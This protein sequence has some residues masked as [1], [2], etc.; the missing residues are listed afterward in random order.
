MSPAQPGGLWQASRQAVSKA[1]VPA[2]AAPAWFKQIGCRLRDLVSVLPEAPARVLRTPGEIDLLR[3]AIAALNEKNAALE[4]QITD[5]SARLKAHV[6][7]GRTGLPMNLTAR[8]QVLKMARNGR[9]PEQ[10]SAALGVPRGEVMLLLQLQIR[11]TQQ[12][13]DRERKKQFEIPK[14]NAGFSR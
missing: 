13:A 12:P 14:T 9:Q 5:L 1:L 10:I 8:G 2:G 11:R 3:V 6:S 4:A 7:G